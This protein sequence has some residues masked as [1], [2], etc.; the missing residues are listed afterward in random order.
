MLYKFLRQQD[1]YGKVNSY[2]TAK[3]GVKLKLNEWKPVLL[4][5]SIFYLE[6]K[7][8][9]FGDRHG[10]VLRPPI[11][12]CRFDSR[13]KYYVLLP[14]NKTGRFHNT[15]SYIPNAFAKFMSVAQLLSDDTLRFYA[16]T[17][18]VLMLPIYNFFIT[19]IKNTLYPFTNFGKGISSYRFGTFFSKWELIVW[20]PCPNNSLVINNL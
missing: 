13:C 10:M 5:F 15:F 20:D 9:T 14:H 6:V 3:V 8:Y 11:C 12:K 17:T 16:H 1:L 4:L 19:K 7:F 18:K 2:F